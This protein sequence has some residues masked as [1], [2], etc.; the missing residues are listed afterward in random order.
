MVEN[1]K[2]LKRQKINDLDRQLRL[3]KRGH[4]VSRSVERFRAK[5]S[6]PEKQLR[7]TKRGKES[8]ASSHEAYLNVYHPLQKIFK[9]LSKCSE[10]RRHFLT[11]SWMI[12][13]GSIKNFGQNI[14]I[15]RTGETKN[16][17]K[18]ATG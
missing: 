9:F 6:D 13:D 4:F 17:S 12:L 3:T 11:Q 16:E 7:L 10:A 2:K 8:D 14:K 1:C 18:I 5:L 15:F